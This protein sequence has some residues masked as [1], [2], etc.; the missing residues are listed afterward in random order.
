[1]SSETRLSMST[2][3]AADVGLGLSEIV[4]SVCAAWGCSNGVL[5]AG[6]KTEEFVRV[7]WETTSPVP[8]ATAGMSMHLAPAHFIPAEPVIQTIQACTNSGSNAALAVGLTETLHQTYKYA[9]SDHEKSW[10][11]D[12]VEGG[13]RGCTVGAL[14][15]FATG[16]DE[17]GQRIASAVVGG[18]V[19]C[20]MGN[21]IAGLG[22]I[23]RSIH[24]PKW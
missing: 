1:M 20:I 3:R 9:K 12:M 23:V 13:Y 17:I 2:E 8:S 18:I 7:F 24:L 14:T 10:G 15:G 21:G 22:H 16:G 4:L 19:G 5:I 6:K 11:T